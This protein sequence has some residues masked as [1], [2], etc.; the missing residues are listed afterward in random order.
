MSTK[1]LEQSDIKKTYKEPFKYYVESNIMSKVTVKLKKRIKKDLG[2]SI[3]EVR[4][5]K[6]GK[7]SDSYSF[8]ATSIENI[9]YGSIENATQ[10]T[11]KK[12]KIQVIGGG[13]DGHREFI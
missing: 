11:T 6:K 1:K 9:E 8:V 3:K 5:L 10:L 12:Q 4:F 7:R 2:I 13:Q